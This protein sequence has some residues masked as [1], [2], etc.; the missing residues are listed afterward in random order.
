MA[1]EEEASKFC[2][3]FPMKGGDGWDNY[4][5]NSTC[6]VHSHE[7]YTLLIRTK[8]LTTLLYLLSCFPRSRRYFE[9]R[10]NYKQFSFLE[11]DLDLLYLNVLI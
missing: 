2:E 9:G 10:T 4:A 7:L 8:K 11:C 5:M 3:G 1:A 6:Q